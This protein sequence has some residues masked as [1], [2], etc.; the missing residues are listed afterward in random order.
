MNSIVTTLLVMMHLPARPRLVENLQLDLLREELCL[1][2]HKDKPADVLL[3][4]LRL[5]VLHEVEEVLHH[6]KRLVD[7]LEAHCQCVWQVFDVWERRLQ[8][9]QLCLLRLR[10]EAAALQDHD[11]VL[12]DRAERG[13]RHALERQEAEHL[14]HEVLAKLNDGQLD[15]GNDL[16]HLH[17]RPPE[18]LQNLPERLEVGARRIRVCQAVVFE[19]DRD[20]R[21]K[22]REQYRLGLLGLRPARRCAEGV[23]E[24]GEVLRVLKLVPAQRLGAHELDEEHHALREDRVRVHKGLAE[25]AALA[26]RKHLPPLPNVA[27]QKVAEEVQELEVQRVA[28]LDRRCVRIPRVGLMGEQAHRTSEARWPRELNALELPLVELNRRRERD[29]RGLVLSVRPNPLDVRVAALVLQE[30][31][32]HLRSQREDA[33]ERLADLAGVVER[34]VVN[35]TK[36]RGGIQERWAQQPDGQVQKHCFA[37]HSWCLGDAEECSVPAENESVLRCLFGERRDVRTPVGVKHGVVADVDDDAVRN[38][39][40]RPEQPWRPEHVVDDG[41]RSVV[42]QL[43]Q[44]VSGCANA[45]HMRQNGRAVLPAHFEK[46]AEHVIGAK[47]VVRGARVVDDAAAAVARV[48]LW[49]FTDG[50]R[51]L[52]LLRRR[53]LHAVEHEQDGDVHVAEPEKLLEHHVLCDA[54][55]LADILRSR[56]AEE[57]LAVGLQASQPVAHVDTDG[58]PLQTR[59]CRTHDGFLNIFDKVAFGVVGERLHGIAKYLRLQWCIRWLALS[60]FWWL[61]GFLLSRQTQPIA[62]RTERWRLLWVRWAF[63]AFAALVL[64]GITA[65]LV[66]CMV[67]KEVTLIA[68][69]LRF[70]V[71]LS[72]SAW[73]SLQLVPGDK[74]AVL[75]GV[76]RR[77]LLPEISFRHP[78]HALWKTAFL[79]LDSGSIA[80]KP[81]KLSPE[82]VILHCFHSKVK[83]SIKGRKCPIRTQREIYLKYGAHSINC[84]CRICIVSSNEVTL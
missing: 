67:M 62:L 26:V 45:L 66:E 8:V 19:L 50:W 70:W 1:P 33:F 84:D 30:H 75:A 65:G 28:V 83:N 31:S 39:R 54:H 27:M 43:R 34:L 46:L 4:A 38:A 47:D 22:A 57:R 7:P 78:S 63:E 72:S 37:G 5:L 59:C 69:V 6:A 73:L 11:Q 42:T 20:E 23:A 52:C 41:V 17:E 25:D 29:H 9:L 32:D 40:F 48:T 16:G 13:R 82:I 49:N 53:A 15:D 44:G 68:V 18:G 74:I 77:A 24:E 56:K 2:K 76:L 71:Y 35:H 21:E 80:G 51:V 36:R 3:R 58:R 79:R 60:G 10:L 61:T 81:R 64:H 55:R 14:V 12:H